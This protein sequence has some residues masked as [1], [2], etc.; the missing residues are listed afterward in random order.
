YSVVLTV[1][2]AASATLLLY[3]GLALHG[4]HLAVQTLHGDLIW[5]MLFELWGYCM[6]GLLFAALIR[7]QVGT[8]AGF[9]LLPG[10]VE[11]IAGIFLKDNRVSLPFTALQQ[12]AM[13]NRVGTTV[14]L[15][16]S[17]A[18]LLV[19]GYLAVGW[20]VAWILFVRRDAN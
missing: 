12:V 1:F 20:A 8:I 16:P 11:T 3:L 17:H 2:I 9:F 4:Q 15:S 10:T 13:L 14:P 18:A 19:L 7:Q 6:F 5:R